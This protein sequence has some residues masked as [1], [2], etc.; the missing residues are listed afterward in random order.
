MGGGGLF[1]PAGDAVVETPCGGGRLFIPFIHRRNGLLSGKSEAGR[2]VRG[3][4]IE[5]CPF[6]DDNKRAESVSFFI[7]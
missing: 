7:K 4:I 6:I 5:I 2:G 3:L 1:I